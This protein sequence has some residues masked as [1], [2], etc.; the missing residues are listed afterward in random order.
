LIL[1]C[2]VVRG[3]PR[4]ASLF[5]ELISPQQELYGR[6]PRQVAS[7]GRFD[8]VGN[9]KWAKAQG[10]TTIL[11]IP[12]HSRK[13]QIKCTKKHMGRGMCTVGK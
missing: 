11:R 10:I 8:S 4:D 1:E 5:S 13:I 6:I 12:G 7:D 3:N 2:P 9:L